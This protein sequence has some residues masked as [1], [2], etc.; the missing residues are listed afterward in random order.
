MND[1]K[2]D[3][4]VESV[5]RIDK[6]LVVNTEHLAEHMRRT[7]LLEQK[8]RPVET[9]VFMVNGIVKFILGLAAIS[10]LFKFFN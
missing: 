3:K 2:L 4:I 5:H 10:A 1:E 6:T 7:D 9:H 8:L